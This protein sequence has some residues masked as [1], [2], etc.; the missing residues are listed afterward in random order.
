M[1]PAPDLPNG[2]SRLS[3][4]NLIPNLAYFLL[5]PVPTMPILANESSSKFRLLC[6]F[7]LHILSPHFINAYRFQGT[8]MV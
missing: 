5:R 1:Y 3:A 6:A 4:L 8:D 7:V 2:N